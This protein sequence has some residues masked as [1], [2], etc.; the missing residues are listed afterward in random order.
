MSSR[1]RNHHRGF[2][3]TIFLFSALPVVLSSSPSAAAAALPLV[4]SS[5][6]PLPSQAPSERSLHLSRA[7]L[8]LGTRLDSV[9]S[10][11][12]RGAHNTFRSRTVVNFRRLTCWFREMTIFLS[13]R[14]TLRT[15]SPFTHFVQVYTYLHFVFL[16]T[17]SSIILFVGPAES[18]R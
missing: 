17:R 9:E 6:C 5:R 16:L 4:A 2:L 1:P 10:C 8:F 15:S 11:T 7:P 3:P 13:R 12:S 18:R 14:Q